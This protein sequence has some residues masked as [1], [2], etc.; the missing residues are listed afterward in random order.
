MWKLFGWLF[1]IPEDKRVKIWLVEKYVSVQGMEP[2]RGRT[3]LGA[4]SWSRFKA[5]FPDEVAKQKQFQSISWPW[6]RDA[7]AAFIILND[8]SDLRVY[9]RRLYLHNLRSLETR[10]MV[11][12]AKWIESLGGDAKVK[13][14]AHNGII[15]KVDLAMKS[16]L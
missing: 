14:Q 11:E 15:A 5:L 1:S 4:M 3:Y 7:Y 6:E 16:I 9:N 12:R 10:S 13:S 2:Q 8:F